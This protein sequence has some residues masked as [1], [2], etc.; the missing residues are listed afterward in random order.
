LIAGWRD[1]TSRRAT[2]FAAVLVAIGGVLA[3]GTSNEGWK[4][5]LPYR[6][7]FEWVPGWGALRAAD[8]AAFIGLLGLGVLGGLGARSLGRWL[9]R[10]G[11][12]RAPAVVAVIAA[13]A[14][15][16]EGYAPWTDLPTVR[17]AAVDEYLARRDDHGAVVYL[18]GNA[19]GTSK[20]DPSLW[21]QP[22]NM[23]GTTAHHRRT[24]NGFS[25]YVPDSYARTFARLLG[26]PGADA[27]RTLRSLGVRYVVV[28]P[29]VAGG[30]WDGL[31]ERDRAR[32][33]RLVGRFGRDLL[34]EVPPGIGARS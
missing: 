1:L 4:Q 32:P 13:V 29:N 11:M 15:L 17:V 30:P 3:L 25:S 22:V 24:P 31:L 33:L 5:Y 34:Y 8:R 21:E 12:R 18:P 10:R 28:H 26:L 16:V 14:I 27:I 9:S 2:V 20:L 6:A 23:Y 19:T 7:L